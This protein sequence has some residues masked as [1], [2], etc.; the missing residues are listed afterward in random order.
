MVISCSTDE[1]LLSHETDIQSSLFSSEARWLSLGAVD[2]GAAHLVCG[3]EVQF[4]LRASANMQWKSLQWTVCSVT[5]ERLDRDKHLKHPGVTLCK[6][7]QML[8]HRQ[9]TQNVT[10]TSA[11]TV[12]VHKHHFSSTLSRHPLTFTLSYISLE[13]NIQYYAITLPRETRAD[14]DCWF[15]L[16]RLHLMQQ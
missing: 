16:P 11:V 14:M 2:A 13:F 5:T 7:K 4:M 8:Q 9:T 15:S 6:N 12:Q 10:V 1:L 3:L